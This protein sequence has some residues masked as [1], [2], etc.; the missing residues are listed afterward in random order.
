[1]AFEDIVGKAFIELKREE[2]ATEEE[3]QEF[4]KARMAPYKVPAVIEFV[5][6]TPR[7]PR[8]RP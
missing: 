2:Q 5:N 6:E 4:C 3:S 1:M 7:V 8:E